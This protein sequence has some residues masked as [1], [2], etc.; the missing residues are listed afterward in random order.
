[1]LILSSEAFPAA[2]STPMKSYVIAN[3][4]QVN[5]GIFK[6]KLPGVNVII[7]FFQAV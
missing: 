7:S 5:D 1:M 2:F 6:W 4:L 3:P